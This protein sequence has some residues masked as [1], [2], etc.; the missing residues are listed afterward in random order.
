MAKAIPN[1]K[2]LTD[3]LIRKVQP[4]SHALLVW[5]THQRGLVLRVETTGHKAFKVI[6]KIGGRAR[7]YHIGAADAIGLAD[8]RKLAARVMF[9]VA[10]GNDPQAQRQ[11][12]R[13]TGTFQD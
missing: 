13:S 1:K 10:E 3:V 12:A 4:K 9:Q 2:K 5:D 6:Y 11:A 8:A 7:W